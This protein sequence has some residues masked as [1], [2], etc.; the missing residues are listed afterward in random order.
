M[1]VLAN[2]YVTPSRIRGVYRYLLLEAS[3]K[4][5][6]RDRLEKL[7]MPASLQSSD[8]AVSR[9]MVHQ[10]IHEGIQMGLFA[11]AEDRVQV[12]PN[13]PKIALSRKSGDR[14]LPLTSSTKAGMIS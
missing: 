13:L 2:P 7:M 10:T 8:K 11:E 3:D 14:V 4:G 5:E 1:S 9:D 6:N 12:H